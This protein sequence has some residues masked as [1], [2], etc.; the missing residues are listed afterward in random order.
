MAWFALPP[1]SRSNRRRSAPTSYAPGPTQRRGIPSRQG[2]Y[3]APYLFKY[4]RRAPCGPFAF[5]QLTGPQAPGA[6]VQWCRG[7]MVPWCH[8]T[9]VPSNGTNEHPVGHLEMLIT[10]IDSPNDK[11]TLE[12]IQDRLRSEILE[13]M[14]WGKNISV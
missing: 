6:M 10:A 7:T 3:G 14:L 8:G 1:S 2:A 11:S 4:I 12:A 5:G 13:H 9:M